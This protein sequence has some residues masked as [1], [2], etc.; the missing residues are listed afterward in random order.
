M[1]DL[2]FLQPTAKGADIRKSE[3]ADSDEEMD[4]AAFGT[5]KALWPDEV[6]DVESG[7]E[8][9]LKRKTFNVNPN[10]TE[11]AKA[12]GLKLLDVVESSSDEEDEAPDKVKKVE[13]DP[14]QFEKVGI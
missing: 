2:A 6:S 4:E 12:K 8:G 5:G 9:L 7:D 3:E 11:K 13:L 1:I 10:L 14:S